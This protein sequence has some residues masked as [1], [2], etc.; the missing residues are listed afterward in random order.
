LPSEN[1]AQRTT[2]DERTYLAVRAIAVVVGFIFYVSYHIPADHVFQRQLSL[3]A[4]ILVALTTVGLGV[5]V[6]LRRTSVKRTMLLVL[7]IDLTAIGIFTYLTVDRDAFFAVC[8]VF[9]IIYGTV[10][11]YREAVL[12]S[13]SVAFAYVLGHAFAP[14]ATALG[15][16]L[17]GLKT[18]SL[19]VIGVIVGNSVDKQRRREHEVELIAYS[20]EILNEQLGRRV[21]ELQAVSEITELVHSSLD[22]DEVGHEVVAI[23]SKVINIPA[24]CV[25]VLDKEK[26]ETLFSASVGVEQLPAVSGSVEI[27]IDQIESYFTCLRVFDYGSMMVLVCSEAAD[28]EQLT[29]EERLVIYAVASELVVAVENSQLYKLTKQLSVTDELTGMFNYRYLQQRIDDEVARAK[30]YSKHV[31]LLMMDADD[32]KMFNDSYG[33]LAGDRAL[34][35]F[36]VV[37]SSVVREVDVVARYGGEEFA[38]VLPETDAAGAFVVAEKIREAIAAHLFGDAEGAR[39]CTLTVSIGVATYPTYAYDKESLLREADDA[40]YRAKN[41]GKNRVRAPKARSEAATTFGE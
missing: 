1:T 34:A 11:E 28:I 2:S 31:S 20:S 15:L 23:L 17:V 40:L 21:S 29:E 13:V 30:R 37:L 4:L 7:P 35:D 22:F 32:F 27:E 6:G 18:L 19:G 12:A 8:V 33:H 36:K 26:S 39:C 10:L 25:F 9:V 14:E 16:T 5:A 41:G 3:W 38:V 24:L